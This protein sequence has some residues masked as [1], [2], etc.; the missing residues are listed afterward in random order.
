MTPAPR[1]LATTTPQFHDTILFCCTLRIP[2]HSTPCGAEAHS[3]MGRHASSG[4]GPAPSY[5][6][7]I[8]RIKETLKDHNE[9]DPHLR[10][11]N[12]SFTVAWIGS[13]PK[14]SAPHVFSV[15]ILQTTSFWVLPISALVEMW[16]LRGF[17]LGAQFC[18]PWL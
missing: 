16:K 2:Y 15:N 17:V 10:F 3:M 1:F 11:Q 5:Q 18:Q 12:L 13:N 7:R 4:S 6:A 8:S 14:P 9:A